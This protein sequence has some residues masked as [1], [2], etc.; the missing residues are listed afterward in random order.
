MPIQGPAAKLDQGEY[1]NNFLYNAGNE[2]NQA[3]DWYE[4]FFRGYDPATGRML[5]I[6]PYAPMYPSYSPFNCGGYS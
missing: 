2:L 4:M 3:S 6:D 1:S 5:Q